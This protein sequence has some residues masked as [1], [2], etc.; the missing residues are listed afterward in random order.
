MHNI[1]KVVGVFA[2]VIVMTIEV[3]NETDADI[4]VE[5]LT[6]Q[7]RFMLNELRIHPESELSLVLV[8]VPRMTELHI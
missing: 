5:V 1:P 3:L 6:R 7:A 2:K 4:D 8:D